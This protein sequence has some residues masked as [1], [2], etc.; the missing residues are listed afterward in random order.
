M[1][2]NTQNLHEY[3]ERLRDLEDTHL[4]PRFLITLPK[5]R[6][7]NPRRL[8][9]LTFLLLIF[10]GGILLNSPWA[11]A[12]GLWSWQTPEGTF[13]WSHGLDAILNNFFMA[14]ASSCVTGL[15]TVDIATYY[16]TFGHAVILG[17]VQL[18]GLSLLTLGTVIM[19]ILLGRVPAGGEA[20]VMLN[21]GHDASSRASNLL[22]QTLR[23]VLTFEV[24]GTLLFFL[25]Y[26]LHYDYTLWKSLWY[27]VFHAITA[28]CNAG[29]SLHEGNLAGFLTDMPYMLIVTTLV[30][31]GGI[32][33]LVIA[34]LTHYHFWKK[35]LRRKGRITLHARIV[36]WT[37]LLLSLFG[38]IV[39]TLL[40]WDGVLATSEG[41][42]LWQ[43]LTACDWHGVG[44]ILYEGCNKICAGF[45][46][47]I[48]TRTAGFNFVPM[49][50]VSSGAN[51]LSVFLMLIGGSPGSMA[52]GIKTTTF[53]VLL[54]T[55]RAYIRGNSYVQVHGRTIR[56]A[57]CREAM[58]IIFFYLMTLFLFYFTLRL[59]EKPLLAARGDFALFYEVTSAIGT[60]GSSLDATQ[61]LT[62]IGKILIAIAMF[63]GRLGPISIALIMAGRE[64]S[65]RTRCPEETITVG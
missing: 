11:Q 34:N 46:Q 47:V 1:K 49:S 3:R 6:Q 2:P 29:I 38:G 27:A 61:H 5:R 14:T 60:V 31:L 24:L 22:W 63:L 19:A 58:V 44:N 64:V 62:P 41:A 26:Y 9:A 35:D 4:E 16:S 52:G 55:I 21:Y 7:F 65:R 42:S 33:F 54:L 40:E 10:V 45:S 12:S 53:V 13:S 37:T 32:G 17:C 50:E 28:F 23:Y 15:T 18:G 8:L 25:R 59:T 30:M 57:I 20:Q 51:Q 56:D 39:F 43:C 36:L 48:V